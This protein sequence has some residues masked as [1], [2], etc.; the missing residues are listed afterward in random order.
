MVRRPKPA[1][2]HLTDYSFDDLGMKEV[3]D[4]QH[5]NFEAIKDACIGY[6][7]SVW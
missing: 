6:H 3:A 5:M 2:Y 4:H 7:V 1:F